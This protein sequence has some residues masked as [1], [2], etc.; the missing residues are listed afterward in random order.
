MYRSCPPAK[1]LIFQRC[2][3]VKSHLKYLRNYKSQKLSFACISSL[4]VLKVLDQLVTSFPRAITDY[5]SLCIIS[6]K[7]SVTGL[8]VTLQSSSRIFQ[9][10]RLTFSPHKRAFIVCIHACTRECFNRVLLIHWMHSCK[11]VLGNLVLLNGFQ[12]HS[13]MEH[14]QNGNRTDQNGTDREWIPNGFRTR[15][16][17]QENAFCQAIPV[18]FLLIGTV[19]L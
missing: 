14:C 9:V 19:Q 17:R 13:P 10:T 11:R 18:G 7:D 5:R 1:F 16:E 12:E 6:E 4:M 15:V 3:S 8:E 2:F